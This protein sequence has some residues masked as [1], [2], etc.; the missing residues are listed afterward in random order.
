M[1]AVFGAFCRMIDS[2]P[3]NGIYRAMDAES[4]MLMEDFARIRPVPL[5]EVFSI[6]HFY[7]FFL[8]ASAVNTDIAPVSVPPEHIDF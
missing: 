3:V 6:L 1:N 4:S 8:L 5:E 7:H 2:L